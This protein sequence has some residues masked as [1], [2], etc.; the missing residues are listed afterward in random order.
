MPTATATSITYAL[1]IAGSPATSSLLGSIQLIEVEDH[2]EMADM[3]RIRVAVSVKDSGSGWTVVDDSVFER[4]T[5]IKLSVTV[6]SGKAVTIFNGYVI[7]NDIEFSN[8]PNGSVLTAVAMDPTVLM[9]LEERVKAWPNMADSDV[10]SAIFSGSDY[11]FTPVVQATNYAPHEDDHTVMQRGTDIQFLQQLANANGYECYIDLNEDSGDVEGHFH[12]PTTDDNPQF[13]LTINMG[14]ATNVNRFRARYDM[15]GPTIATGTTVDFEQKSNESGQAD[16]SNQTSLGSDD[17]TSTDRPRKVLL[18][19]LGMG[20][21][22]EVQRYAQSVVDRSSWAITAEGELNTAAFGSI[23][24]AKQ[25]ITVRGVGREFSGLYYV[26]KVVHLISSD[27]NY[28]QR[29]TLRRN[30][31]GLTGREQFTEQEQ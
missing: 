13:T 9:H 17:S 27:G 25:P 18:S 29:F 3:L 20:Q 31:L 2:S 1:S 30:A 7:E 23:L 11:G 14:S 10:A 5:S 12:P 21:S 22:A 8:Q 24:R 4:L 26:Y 6:G 15:L 16:S 28:L 19:G